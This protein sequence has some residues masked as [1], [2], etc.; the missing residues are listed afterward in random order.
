MKYLK[1]IV[2]QLLFTTLIYAQTEIKEGYIITNNNDTL[3]GYIEKDSHLKSAY[4]CVFKKD[5]NANDVIRYAPGEIF[6][7]GYNGEK[8]FIS[9]EIKWKDSTKEILFLEYLINGIVDIYYCKNNEGEHYFLDSEKTGFIELTG[10]K[11]E[12]DGK[13]SDYIV[14]NTNHIGLLRL[15]FADR[16]DFFNQINNVSVNH[17]SLIN[18]G[19]KYHNL[20]CTDEK[21]IIYSNKTK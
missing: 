20:V 8:F 21:C 9:R 11:N 5:L 2:F 10:G 19:E 7:Y 15:A 16:P 17:N 12:I 3:H 1:I 4:Q 14:K 6:A 18:V 13:Y